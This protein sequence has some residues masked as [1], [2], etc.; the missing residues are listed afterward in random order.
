VSLPRTLESR[1][2]LDDVRE[3]KRRIKAAPSSF[4]VVLVSPQHLDA[5]KLHIAAQPITPSPAAHLIHFGGGLAIVVQEEI[6]RRLAA[7]T[8]AVAM[9]WDALR[10]AEAWLAWEAAAQ[11]A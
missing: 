8:M 5:L 4:E 6:R 9:S 1:I 10:R 7:P 2:S 3:M 11:I